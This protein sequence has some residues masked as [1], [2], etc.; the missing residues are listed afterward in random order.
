MLIYLCFSD[1]LGFS[2]FFFFPST[3][4]IER[5]FKV[6]PL[7]KPQLHDRRFTQMPVILLWVLSQQDPV[8]PQIGRKSTINFSVPWWLSDCTVASF[9]AIFYR[10]A[11]EFVLNESPDKVRKFFSFS[12]FLSIFFFLLGWNIFFFRAVLLGRTVRYWGTCYA[13]QT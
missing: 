5:N 3:S 1:I 6:H 11:K 9:L 8:A 7:Q 13:W 12:L 10:L 2:C 4:C